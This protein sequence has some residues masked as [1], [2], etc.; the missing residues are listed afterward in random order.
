MKR[1]IRLIATAV[2]AVTVVT[3]LAAKDRT[4]DERV[5]SEAK[6]AKPHDDR[7][8]PLP[9][10]AKIDTSVESTAVSP[11]APASQQAEAPMAGEQIDWWVIGVGGGSASSTSFS[12]SGTV[13][14]PAVGMA[15]SSSYTVNQGF[16]Q[17]FSSGTSGCC[18]GSTGNVNG[19]AGE[20]VDLSDLIYLVN[21]LFLGGPAPPCVGEAN[22]NGDIGCSVDLSDLIYLVN[23]LFLGGPAPAACLPG[24]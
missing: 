8:S 13:G 2:L 12:L 20:A 4:L 11:T 21:Y 6:R 16:W 22:T 19:D 10:E 5:S 18:I 1:T 23:Y 15:G 24:C 14:Q 7:R 3:S 9:A 17:D